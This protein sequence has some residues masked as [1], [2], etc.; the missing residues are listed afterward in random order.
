LGPIGL[1]LRGLYVICDADTGDPVRVAAAAH[2][3]G[4]RLFQV[5]AKGWTFDDA[6]C[7]GRQV[8]ASA[9]GSAVFANDDPDLV[10]AIGA[11][12][13]HLGQTDG[14]IASA[15]ARMPRG[16]WVARST[17]SAEDLQAAVVEGA[18]A[19]AFGPVWATAR[20]SRPKDVRGVDGLRRAVAAAG[21]RVPVIAIGG[22]TAARVPELRAAGAAA[23]ATIG[24]VGAAAD[25]EAAARALL[26]A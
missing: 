17:N 25:P 6:V 11:V 15:R 19:V 1:A 12:G 18:D 23:W 5:R 4:C 7:L 14:S 26:S 13:V 10:A 21:G 22:V 8:V 16:A 2:A 24:A 9:P 20:L 3:A